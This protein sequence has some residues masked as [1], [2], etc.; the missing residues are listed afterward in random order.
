MRL[1]GSCPKGWPP[2]ETAGSIVPPAGRLFQAKIVHSLQCLRLVHSRYTLYGHLLTIAQSRDGLCFAECSPPTPSIAV[3]PLAA[4]AP[5][6]GMQCWAGS[7]GGGWVS[8]SLA[9]LCP[10]IF[11]CKPSNHGFFFFSF[12]YRKSGHKMELLCYRSSIVLRTPCQ[13]R[14]SFAGVV[15]LSALCRLQQ[16]Q[17]RIPPAGGHDARYSTCGNLKSLWNSGSTASFSLWSGDAAAKVPV[18]HGFGIITV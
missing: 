8:T 3:L 12:R 15:L 10:S 13:I 5:H 9:T 1:R 16:R 14:E 7:A 17:L 2:S 11:L 18:P 6:N 4:T